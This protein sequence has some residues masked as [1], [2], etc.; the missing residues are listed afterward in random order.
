[1]QPY[2]RESSKVQLP[3]RLSGRN[4]QSSNSHS[5]NR[6]PANEHPRKSQSWNFVPTKVAILNN[7]QYM[8]HC[9]NVQSRKA[10]VTCKP[11]PWIPLNSQK[12]KTCSSQVTL[13][14][15]ALLKD[16]ASDLHPAFPSMKVG[17]SL[18]V[19]RQGDVRFGPKAD[20]S[21]NR[22]ATVRPSVR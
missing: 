22:R 4:R 11:S 20:I 17:L 2:H 5:T 6:H 7:A 13:F 19:D 10:E 3:L 1:M 15:K 18:L 21:T 14:R 8:S 16:F 9:L 12:M